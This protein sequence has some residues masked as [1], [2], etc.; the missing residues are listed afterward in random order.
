[1]ARSEGATM[2]RAIFTFLT[3]SLLAIGSGPAVLAQDELQ[4]YGPVVLGGRIE[5]PSAGFALEV[6]EDWYAFDL[7]H[8]DL[9]EVMETFDDTTAMLAPN[10]A[11][12]TL[13]SLVPD[14]ADE[15]P[16]VAMPFIAFAPFW[17]PTA[18]EAC[19][20]TTEPVPTDSVEFA[21]AGQ[22]PMMRAT[23][24]LVGELEPR[25]IDLPAGRVGLLEYTQRQAGVELDQTLYY[26]LNEERGYAL[27]CADAAQHAER[28]LS[29]AESV[30]FLP[31]G[32]PVD[33]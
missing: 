21:L 29:I 3:T 12:L 33:M 18:G 24:D 30:E 10:M 5:V 6:P 7:S 32:A 15:F 17:G 20:M 1:M 26:F 16:Q 28:W 4:D 23:F 25:F 27:T 9:V 2:R 14:L 19:N 22:L 31:G 13:D 8:P 11:E